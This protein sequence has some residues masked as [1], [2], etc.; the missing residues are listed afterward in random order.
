ME[1][2]QLEY[3][4]EVQ[5][6]Y[7]R[8]TLYQQL[9]QLVLNR[10]MVVVLVF[11]IG[12]C[13]LFL[14]VG[15]QQ[16]E[17]RHALEV[18]SFKDAFELSVDNVRTNI[19]TLASNDL[20]INALID[21]EMRD[22]YLP[23]FFQSLKISKGENNFSALYDFSGEIIQENNW[24]DALVH[25]LAPN[26]KDIVLVQGEVLEVVSPQGLLII[27]PILI[28]GYAEGALAGFS[29]N[30]T[31]LRHLHDRQTTQI[32]FNQQGQ[33]IA[34]SN[35]RY[36]D[37]DMDA[38]LT[39]KNKSF[40][41]KTKFKHFDIVSSQS[42]ASAYA[43]SLWLL[44]IFLIAILGTLLT[45]WYAVRLASAQS[46]N[47]LQRL[48]NA[49][50][51][52]IQN[53]DLEPP[54]EEQGSDGHLDEALELFNI[55]A[56]FNTLAREVLSLSIS[57]TK[58]NNVIN[59]LT[60]FLLVVDNEGELILENTTSRLTAIEIGIEQDL[61]I[62]RAL[63][64]LK[65]G[66]TLTFST[67]YWVSG[68]HK[69]T[70]Q[71][72]QQPT[73]RTI[74]W[75]V[76][77][78][79]NKVGETIGAIVTGQDVS[80]RVMLE[81]DIKVRN[82]ALE[83]SPVPVTIV[84]ITKADQPFIYVNKAFSD[85]TGYSYEEA[86]GRSCQFL[87]GK[88]YDKA[89]STAI[90][91]AIS[92][93][94]PLNCEVDNYRKDGSK[95]INSLSIMPVID[96][97]AS[98][99]YYVGV[100]QDITAEKQTA[101]LLSQAKESAERTMESQASFFASINHELRTPINGINGMLKALMKTDLNQQQSKYASLA[102]KS[103][104]NLLLIVNDVLDY[105]KAES[106]Q[107]SIEKHPCDVYTFLDEVCQRMET[108]CHSKSLSFSRSI[109][110][111]K[112]HTFLIDAMRVQQ[113]IE[114]IY[115]NALKFT[116]TGTISLSV[117]LNH[118]QLSGTYSLHFCIKDSG[119]GIAQEDLVDI[120]ESFKQVK[121]ASNKIT[122]GTG[123]GL[124][125][126]KQLVE[127]MDGEIEAKSKVNEGSCFH[128][129]VRTEMTEALVSSDNG[130][131]PKLTKGKTPNVLIVEDN[132]I[133]QEVLIATLTDTK[134]IVAHNGIQALE[135]LQ[136][137]KVP[138]DVILMDCQMPELDGWQTTRMIRDGEAGAN[139]KDVPII[140][141]TAFTT[142]SDKQKCRDAGMDAYLSKPFQPQSLQE[143][144]MTWSTKRHS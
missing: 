79:T 127:L 88:Q 14:W 32:L 142:S 82:Q 91:E 42:F 96:S 78:F 125:I 62:D 46:A 26:W 106:G 37:L 123:L 20:L 43:Q 94:E 39:L 60:E 45:S 24:P 6:E 15:E 133:N 51:K 107:L 109:E 2:K 139:Y 28:S 9:Q 23:L 53:E 129:S 11:S 65:S 85:M 84:D 47:T 126:S 95:F 69:P 87:Q 99:R 128:F 136:Q 143:T 21:F 134:T 10:V 58:I 135:V 144:V 111:L 80:E 118:E 57:N 83:A 52:Q 75:R 110:A 68:S 8:P 16:L 3:N 63:H 112:G 72:E 18:E 30:I 7:L 138:I 131:I 76:T 90:F 103:A 117:E 22:E 124:T 59:S 100:Q 89:T 54:E 120:F 115:N 44:P 71:E 137:I 49:L 141:I 104:D 67:K 64:V 86:V 77:R 61:I 41:L 13:G 48:H 108:Q 140:A 1:A 105:S 56:S 5:R 36:A 119:I 12:I 35:N 38:F 130:D 66:M 101:L 34:A 116:D 19:V 50:A 33:Q 102:N 4:N 70:S 113:V 73:L 81:D 31:S 27:A 132:E 121:Q 114:N 29:E 74:D 17:Q 97:D 25:T 122:T 40:V 92:K 55:R 98:V 93:K